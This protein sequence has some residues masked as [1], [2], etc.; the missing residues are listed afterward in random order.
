MRD[1][2]EIDDE[3]LLAAGSLLAHAATAVIDGGSSPPHVE[4]PLVTG[5]GDRVRWFLEGVGTARAAL[6]DA[7]ATTGRAVA[8]VMQVSAELDARLAG[9]LGDGFAVPQVRRPKT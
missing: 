7:A 5:F 6:A 8:E 1:R 2:F 3:S 9:Q 4:L